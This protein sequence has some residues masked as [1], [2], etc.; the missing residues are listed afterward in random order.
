MEDPNRVEL[1]DMPGQPIPWHATPDEKV[2]VKLQT[3][4]RGLSPAQV[5]ERLREFGRNTLPE[6]KPPTLVDI[7]LHQFKSP[8]IDRQRQD[9]HAD[10]QSADCARYRLSRRA[11]R[12]GGWPG[13]QR[14]ARGVP[15]GCPGWGWP[16]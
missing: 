4:L 14:S 13:L 12:D 2:L 1:I 6:R 8:L 3:D 9:R 11:A 5:E 7:I 16:G 10:R 15:G